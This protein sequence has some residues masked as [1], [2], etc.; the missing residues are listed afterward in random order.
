M[1]PLHTLP[2]TAVSCERHQQPWIK[3]AA[4][5][6]ASGRV[7][8]SFL[9]GGWRV[10][11]VVPPTPPI[12]SV[13]LQETVSDG[14]FWSCVFMYLIRSRKR[15]KDLLLT[16]AGTL[17]V[18]AKVGDFKMTL[19]I[20]F[21]NSLLNIEKYQ[22]GRQE[23]LHTNPT[24]NLWNKCYLDIWWWSALLVRVW[25]DLWGKVREEP[26]FVSQLDISI[27]SVWSTDNLWSFPGEDP[28]RVTAGEVCLRIYKH[29]YRPVSW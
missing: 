1:F 21:I 8:Y 7:C 26:W 3:H 25:C 13:A 28:E 5:S 20:N 18:L 6:W 24:V 9:R 27:G 23:H 17:F 10:T 12:V 29:S 22:Y 4:A 2:D 15:W 16:F 14:L 11:I 19:D